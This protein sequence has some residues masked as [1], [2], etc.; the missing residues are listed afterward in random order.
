MAG[1]QSFKQLLHK[2]QVLRSQ[3]CVVFVINVQLPAG[4]Q[5]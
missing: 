2:K 5:Y 3:V 4:M 1:I